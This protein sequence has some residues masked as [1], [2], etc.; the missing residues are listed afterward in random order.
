[1]FYSQVIKTKNTFFRLLSFLF[2]NYRLN[3]HIC[4]GA[5]A[6]SEEDVVRQRTNTMADDVVC[7]SDDD[8]RDDGPSTST[9]PN[10]GQ[11]P[12]WPPG[13]YNVYEQYMQQNTP[14]VTIEKAQ[15]S[16]VDEFYDDRDGVVYVPDDSEEENFLIGPIRKKSTAIIFGSRLIAPIEFPYEM[17][18]DIDSHVEKTLKNVSVTTEKN[19]WECILEQLSIMRI[20]YS[21]HI[22]VCI[23]QSIFY[24]VGAPKQYILSTM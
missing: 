14:S 18:A 16:N 24:Q 12:S 22:D 15:Q 10:N 20:A 2:I 19:I 7:I 6:Q 21:Q 8:E 9:N 17:L 4:C 3:E 5:M 23:V 11:L 13:H 1:M